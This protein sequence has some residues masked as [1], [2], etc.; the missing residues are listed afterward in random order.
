[1][2][3]QPTSSPTVHSTK[4][5]IM[6]Q[7][8]IVATL[9]SSIHVSDAFIPPIIPSQKSSCPLKQSHFFSRI[10]SILNQGKIIDAE[11]VLD[12]DENDAN[13]YQR[14][15]NTAIKNAADMSLIEYS[16][17]QDRDWKSMPVA[18]CDT[19]SNTYI[20]CNLAFYVKDPLNSGVEYA[21]GVPCEIPIVVALECDEDDGDDAVAGKNK[22]LVLVNNQGWREEDMLTNLSKVIPINPDESIGGS[23]GLNLSEQEKEEI[24]QMAAH[25][26]MEEFGPN[27]RLKKTPRVLTLEGDL[28]GVIGDWKDVLLGVGGKKRKIGKTTISDE[29]DL[30]EAMSII[31]DDDEGDEDGEDYFDQI[32]RRDFGPDYMNLLDDSDGDDDEIDEEI[33]KIFEM[34]DESDDDD[35]DLTEMLRFLND[36]EDDKDGKSS[37]ASSSINDNDDL[38]QQLRPSAALNI[39]TFVGPNDREY[40]ILRPLRPILLVGK[41]DTEDFTRRMLLTNEEMKKVLPRLERSCRD[42]LETAGFFLATSSKV[43]DERE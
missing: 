9:L 13:N 3:F 40:S 30:D 10:V 25:A 19:E 16:Q 38:L 32:M 43:T 23:D 37:G 24:F 5:S 26:L 17:N 31:E 33:L 34:D 12:D 27:I 41:E 1:M 7:S 42:D 15:Y 11:F 35:D 14:S 22:D 6:R 39:L 18:F 8:G 4:K 2:S 21:L 29:M 36:N 28:E 20:D